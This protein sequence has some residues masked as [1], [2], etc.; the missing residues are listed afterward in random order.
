MSREVPADMAN[1]Y[2]RPVGLDFLDKNHVKYLSIKHSPAFTAQEIAEL[3]H[4]HGKQMAKV[5]MLKI[6]GR[7]DMS[8]TGPDHRLDLTTLQEKI[9]CTN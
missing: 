2:D 6:D 3:S 9:P 4:I 5:V 8:V 7:M 1:H